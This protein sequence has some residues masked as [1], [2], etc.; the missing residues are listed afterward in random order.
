MSH[1]FVQCIIL[2]CLSFLLWLDK[3]FQTWIK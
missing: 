1:V 2:Y 3:M